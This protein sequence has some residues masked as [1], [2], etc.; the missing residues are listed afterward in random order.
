MASHHPQSGSARPRMSAF[1]EELGR[2]S[3]VYSGQDEKVRELITSF[4]N[5]GRKFAAE[6]GC[7]DP[8]EEQPNAADQLEYLGKLMGKPA[9][10]L[11]AQAAA[12][13]SPSPSEYEPQGRATQTKKST[14]GQWLC[15]VESAYG[16]SPTS[17]RD[18]V[19]KAWQDTKRNW[20]RKDTP[21]RKALDGVFRNLCTNLKNTQQ[22]AQAEQWHAA[23]LHKELDT[24][25]EEAMA[26]FM[27]VLQ[28]WNTHIADHGRQAGRKHLNT[29]THKM[30]NSLQYWLDEVDAAYGLPRTA[31][32]TRITEA[33]EAVGQ[34]WP[35]RGHSR[36]ALDKAF[37]ELCK[38]L[39]SLH[40]S[41]QEHSWPDTELKSNMDTKLEAAETNLRE[42]FDDVRNKTWKKERKRK[43]PEPGEGPS[44]RPN[45]PDRTLPAD[46]LG[47][48]PG[49]GLLS[50][51]QRA[52]Y[53]RSQPWNPISRL[54]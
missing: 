16:Q 11:P 38:S 27:E 31:F 47:I 21:E 9:R 23:N 25:L 26:Q 22:T 48:S 19:V 6:V 39:E 13:T 15:K 12:H 28:Q 52:I 53:T 35:G 49:M 54:Q 3:Q 17:F 36:Q 33:W 30:K 37:Q 2:I 40:R 50:P 1:E 34:R 29:N 46:S 7:F 18:K 14:L 41:A 42:V 10:G 32:R 4:V 43:I 44:R 24:Q 20:P 45:S 51:R 8:V 5:A